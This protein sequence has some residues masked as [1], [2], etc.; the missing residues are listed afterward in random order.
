MSIRL[1]V[2]DDDA[3]KLHEE[4]TLSSLIIHEIVWII[5]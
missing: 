5:T 3:G 1:S 4:Q 2:Q